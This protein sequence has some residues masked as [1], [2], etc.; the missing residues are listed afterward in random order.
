MGGGLYFEHGMRTDWSD[1]R[2][3]GPGQK[4]TR[5]SEIGIDPKVAARSIRIRAAAALN[6]ARHPDRA[7]AKGKTAMATPTS[8]GNSSGSKGILDLIEWIGNKLPDPATLFLIGAAIVMLLSFVLAQT[9]TNV[10]PMRP[11]QVMA[12]VLDAD[13]NAVIDPATG[14]PKMEAALDPT[15]G[16]PKLEWS[17]SGAPIEAENLISREGLFWC[18]NT[19]VKNFIEFAPLGIVLTGMLGIGVAERTGLLGAL[20][21]AFMLVVPEWALTPAM[22]FIGVMSSA[23]LDAGYIVLP[24]HAAARGEIAG[25]SPLAGLAAVFAG[26]AAGF[27]ANLLITGLDPLLSGL[28]TAA[29]R[30]VN[31]NYTVT[32][33]C[34]W[35]FLIASTFV[36]TLA[37]WA[38]TAWFVERRMASKP[39]EEGGPSPATAADLE[40]QQLTSSEIKGLKAGIAVVLITLGALVAISVIPGAPLYTYHMPTPDQTGKTPVAEVW[41]PPAPDAPIPDNAYTRADGTIIVPT[42]ARFS[43]WVEVVVPMIFLSFLLPG[44]AY[45]ITVGKI[46]SDKD[47][48]KLF[49]DSMATMGPIIV[50]AFFAGQFIGYF[51]HSNLGVM[52]AEWGGKTLGQMNMAPWALMVVFI[53]V[54]MFFNL[55]VGSMSAKYAMFAPIFV[56]MFMLVGI[57]P[58]LTQGAYRVGDSVTN[59]I[60]PLN[61]Y[62]V[63]I[64]VFM[65]EYVPKGGIGTLIAAMVPYTIVF[66]IVW[67]ILLV[68]WMQMGWPL[69][70]N[71]GLW[72]DVTQNAAAA[73][74][75]A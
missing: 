1:P 34:N 51:N 67:T 33:P 29:A 43:R 12:P 39:P 2:L 4:E 6:S 21:K 70:P 13:G 26:V 71:S 66:T 63:I 30:I 28:S 16:K 9:G 48:A 73:M 40:A 53:G 47:L 14:E 52:L 36:I 61:P 19:M 5:R 44:L 45:G 57:S 37:G 7:A 62:L 68:I 46:R 27:N 64:L 56:P 23:A 25:R 42:D 11:H 38:V 24:P 10:Q 8:S 50:L 41:V 54:V 22:V 15:T 74:T 18:F 65:K 32:P 55:F 35:Y 75:G 17:R 49:I 3:A 20:M 60:T 31:P 69:G 72:Y 59:V 58:E